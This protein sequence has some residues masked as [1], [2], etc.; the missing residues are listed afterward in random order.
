MMN[1]GTVG[2]GANVVEESD[3]FEN[4]DVVPCAELVFFHRVPHPAKGRVRKG[5]R[6]DLLH[7]FIEP[8]VVAPEIDVREKRGQVCSFVALEARGEKS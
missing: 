8:H 3:E 6:V 5:L 2:E 1:F 7:F 4:V